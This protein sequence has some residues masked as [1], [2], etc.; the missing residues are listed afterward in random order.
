MVLPLKT[1]KGLLTYFS[2]FSGPNFGL[3][4]L[5]KFKN[6]GA[7]AEPYVWLQT[8]Q[9]FEET[10]KISL[11]LIHFRIQEV[12]RDSA[13]NLVEILLRLYCSSKSSWAQRFNEN[14]SFFD[15]SEYLEDLKI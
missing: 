5:E 2:Q 1:D 8:F 3:V 9:D 6:F 15:F 10:K 7:S 11:L 12:N 4:E 13:L 14:P